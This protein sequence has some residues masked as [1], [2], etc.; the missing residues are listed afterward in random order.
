MMMKM[1]KDLYN[2]LDKH[3][4]ELMTLNPH[5]YNAYKEAGLSDIRYRWD[6]FWAVQKHFKTDD[7]RPSEFSGLSDDHI[8]TALRKITGTK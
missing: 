2:R 8:D 4:K 5:L 6:L 1:S 3:I 7:H